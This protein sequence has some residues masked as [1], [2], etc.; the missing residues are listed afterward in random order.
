MVTLVNLF[1]KTHH[2][3]KLLKIMWL[4]FSGECVNDQNFCLS[5]I[6]RSKVKFLF[7]KYVYNSAQHWSLSK[8]TQ[9]P[10]T[11]KQIRAFL[12]I[13]FNFSLLD[14][15]LRLQVF[16]SLKKNGVSEKNHTQ[17]KEAYLRFCGIF[18]FIFD[19]RWK[20]SFS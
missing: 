12:V 15:M 14:Q 2:F 3:S 20:C 10:K 11:W 5:K 19:K 9:M 8:V 7:E 13:A 18:R 17:Q 4:I 16:F 6:Q 1:L